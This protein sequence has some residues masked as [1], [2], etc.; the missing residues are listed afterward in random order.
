MS[1]FR[2]LLT[3]SDLQ[4]YRRCCSH[5]HQRTE[6]VINTPERRP[7]IVVSLE[8]RHR[9]QIWKALHNMKIDI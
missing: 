1:V 7:A 5:G 8:P 2:T 4:G 3:L 9:R 6:E